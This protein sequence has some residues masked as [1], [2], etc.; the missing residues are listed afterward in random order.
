ML[1]VDLFWLVSVF[2]LKDMR[3]DSRESEPLGEVY[4]SYWVAM[5]PKMVMFDM[6]GTT[7]F[8]RGGVAKV[9]SRVFAEFGAELVPGSFVPLMGMPVAAA[10]K[11]GMKRAKHERWEDE[12]F[13]K[14]VAA[15]LDD[16][17]I[18]HFEHEG[19]PVPGAMAVF[20]RLKQEGVF[21]VLDTGLSRRVADAVLA[22]LGWKGGI[23][24]FTISCDEVNRPKPAPD[25]IF[26]SMKRFAIDNP[27]HVAKVGDTPNDLMMGNIGGCGYVIGVTEGTH[28]REA[29]LP[30]PHTHLVANVNDLPGIFLS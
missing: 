23:I 16:E 14:E 22:K 6:A 12:S 13:L 8:D 27:V 11:G 21:V 1:H 26:E 18:I 4:G 2:G 25:M 15:R 24:D 30:Y 20:T 17:L 7:V 5:K 19:N 9:M 3:L 28:A 10:V 29:L